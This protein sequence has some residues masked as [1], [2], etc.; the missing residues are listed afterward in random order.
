MNGV[1]KKSGNRIFSTVGNS[2]KNELTNGLPAS[3]GGVVF[4]S[5][6]HENNGDAQSCAQRGRICKRSSVVANLVSHDM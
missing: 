6:K 5:G 1:E 4:G 3:E 2:L